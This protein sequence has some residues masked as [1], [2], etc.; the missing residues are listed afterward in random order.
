M[1][2]PKNLNYAALEKDAKFTIS[3]FTPEQLEKAGLAKTSRTVKLINI[4]LVVLAS[5]N[6]FGLIMGAINGSID[7]WP[8]VFVQIIWITAIIVVIFFIPKWHLNSKLKILKFAHDNGLDYDSSSRKPVSEQI[9]FKLGHSQ[10]VND[11]LS[12][13]GDENQ[14]A[15][16]SYTVGHGKSQQTYTMN[17]MMLK[18]PRRLPHLLL[19]SHKNTFAPEISGYKVEKLK[20]EGDFAK[21]FTLYAPPQYRVD[22]LQVF[23]PDVMAALIDHGALYDYEILDDR[24]YIYASS[25]AL[26][27]KDTLQSFLNSAERLA[28]EFSHQAKSCKDTAA[29]SF[30]ENTI[31]ETGARLQKKQWSL[32]SQ[33]IIVIVI[34]AAFVLFNIFRFLSVSR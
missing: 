12:W 24:L 21:T 26:T 15:R 11:V 29:Q 13:P 9:M 2:N 30:A 4:L 6:L 18:L 22:A 32:S 10:K 5:I 34:I 27:K 3:D 23:T 28:T 14:L 33:T 1:L 19:N 16:F 8:Q 20:L 17:Y 25:F 31:A 7:N